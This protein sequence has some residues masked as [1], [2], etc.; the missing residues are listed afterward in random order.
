MF[1]RNKSKQLVDLVVGCY[2]V[3]VHTLGT[4]TEVLVVKENIFTT[5]TSVLFKN[6]NHLDKLILKDLSKNTIQKLGI[7]RVINIRNRNCLSR[8]YNELLFTQVMFHYRSV[9]SS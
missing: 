1:L 5:S 2:Q 8:G 7:M 6:I 9:L 3:T 4:Y